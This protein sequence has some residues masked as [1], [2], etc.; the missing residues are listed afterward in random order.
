MLSFK[1]NYIF[2]AVLGLWCCISFSLVAGRRGCS[3]AAG[4]RL[5]AAVA[6]LVARHG[7]WGMWASGATACVLSSC[8]SWALEHRLNSGGT[9][10]QLLNSMWDFPVSGI[11]PMSPALADGFFATK[12]PGKSQECYHFILFYFPSKSLIFLDLFL[13]I[14]NI[15]LCLQFFYIDRQFI[16]H[17]L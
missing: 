8:S 13:Y 12:L 2:L 15:Q 6:S 4:L 11:K 14:H 16:Q 3:L 5:L 1:K 7:L 17:N 9:W 10:A